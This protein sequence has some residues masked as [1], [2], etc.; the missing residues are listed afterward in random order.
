[1]TFYDVLI[2]IYKG[3]EFLKKK[4]FIT[5]F[6]GFVAGSV[7]AQAKENWDI[8]TV[9]RIDIP[10][11]RDAVSYYRLDLMDS[12]NLAQLFE[13]VN[14]DAV[15][16][17]AALADIDFCQNNREQ[18]E[19]I[20]VGVTRKIAELCAGNGA[21]LVFCSTDTVFDGEKGFYTEEDKPHPINFYAETK[22]RA[23]KIVNALENSVVARLSLVMGLPVMG[24]GNSFLARTIEKLSAGESVKFPQNEIRTPVDVITLGRALP[25]LAGNDFSGTVHL[26]GNDR[27]TRYDMARQI[28][29][30]LGYS[31]DLIVATNSNAMPGRAPRPN[32]AS[33]NNSKA[34]EI[35]QTPMRSLMAGL[36]L[37]LN[38]E[39][40]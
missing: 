17:T 26:A 30:R 25:E 35:L 4:L 11:N 12:E 37:T 16:H 32:D 1:L 22:V 36:D 31:P 29:E 38:F 34:K 18:A 23:E 10:E 19:A 6:G 7:I 14:P 20:N 15:I 40:G 24:K 2:Y 8:H 27:L 9:D 5:G 3:G 33:L 39:R 28:A 13:E 21:K